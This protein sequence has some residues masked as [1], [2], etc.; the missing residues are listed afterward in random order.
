[1]GLTI[2][3]LVGH[4]YELAE[5]VGRGGM[6][7]VFRA[8]DLLLH[9]D[10]AVKVLRANAE[11]KADQAGFM[12]EARTLARL[13]HPGLVTVFDAGTTHGR[14]FLVME[15]VEGDTLAEFCAQNKPTVE[16]V[17]SLGVQIGD[18][19]EQVHAAGIVHRDIKPGNVLVDHAGRVRLIDF[20]IA[21]PVGLATDHTADGDLVGTAAY[22]SPEQFQGQE[23]GP[24][25]DVYSMG[26]VLLEVLTGGRAFPGLP[27]ESAV[28]RLSTDPPIPVS[29]PFE[30]RQLLRRM[31][32]REPSARPAVG[33]AAASLRA[34][35]AL[36]VAT[37]TA[38]QTSPQPTPR[39]SPPSAPKRRLTC[40]ARQA[41]DR[42]SRRGVEAD[43]APLASSA[44][45][46][47]D[48]TPRGRSSVSAR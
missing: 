16:H 35:A 22:L 40:C 14:P 32:A 6:A 33:K 21:L 41:P 3:S 27:I 8:R 46:V 34:L 31:T 20:G 30:L 4:R 24:A 43:A 28:S 1:M 29:L 19:L 7:D 44:I 18:A 11:L 37:A 48:P 45:N 42:H 10:V 36:P 23:V 13:N 25:S 26:L 2:T 15:L 9:R 5:A 47:E 39:P 12:R 17:L 38:P